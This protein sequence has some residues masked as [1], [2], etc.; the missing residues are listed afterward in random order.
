MSS[1][2]RANLPLSVVQVVDSSSWV[3]GALVQLENTVCKPKADDLVLNYC[4]ICP[5]VR[6]FR[7][8][9][10]SQSFLTDVFLYMDKTFQGRLLI[11]QDAG[12]SKVSLATDE[13]KKAAQPADSEHE[14]EEEDDQSDSQS[15]DGDSQGDGLEGAKD[16][17]SSDMESAGDQGSDGSGSGDEGE[18]GP[19]SHVDDVEPQCDSQE[20]LILPGRDQ[21]EM[22]DQDP[23]EVDDSQPNPAPTQ[24][25]SSDSDVES[26]NTPDRKISWNEEFF[27]TPR[28]GN[29]GPR[30]AEIVEMCMALMQYFGANH[31]DIV[32]S[33]NVVDYMDH[34]E[35]AYARFGVRAT[36]WLSTRDHWEAWLARYEA[37]GNKVGIAHTKTNI[38]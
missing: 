38:C 34:C 20:T 15:H 7:S 18:P 2:L 5:F 19:G 6:K 28:F 37:R 25:E 27:T 30:R 16:G 24:S 12:E 29:S 32:K 8:Q 36:N 33:P 11:P 1:S 23:M 14:E 10:P 3:G 13:A 31:P 22:D 26:I 4:W 17:E 35:W 21:H 9:I